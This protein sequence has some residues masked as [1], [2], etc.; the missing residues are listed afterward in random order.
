MKVLGGRFG[1]FDRSYT[2]FARA[3][4]GFGKGCTGLPQSFKMHSAL[5]V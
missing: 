1:G 4:I 3:A 2:G 5:G